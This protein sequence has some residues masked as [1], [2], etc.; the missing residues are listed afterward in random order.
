MIK[1]R[2]MTVNEVRDLWGATLS[3]KEKTIV[4]RALI[5]N[6]ELNVTYEYSPEGR[7]ILKLEEVRP[8]SAPTD[9]D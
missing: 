8:C 1:T 7:S 4:S 9:A 3:T 6:S 2:Q 5:N